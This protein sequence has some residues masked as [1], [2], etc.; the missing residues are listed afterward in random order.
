MPRIQRPNKPGREVP[1]TRLRN[2]KQPHAVHRSMWLLLLACAHPAPPVAPDPRDAPLPELCSREFT[3]WQPTREPSGLVVMTRQQV[4]R[5]V[6]PSMVTG[7]AGAC[8][9]I[10]EG[11]AE[12]G[13]YRLRITAQP[14]RGVA[15]ARFRWS[16]ARE[17]ALSEC[18][19]VLETTYDAWD[20]P[21]SDAID[22][23]TPPDADCAATL[24]YPLVFDLSSPGE[25]PPGSQRSSP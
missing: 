1:T 13:S 20:M 22:P 7:L 10:A 4:G 3:D 2:R 18:V 8:A 11:S 5:M 6:A 24:V 17:G 23:T 9:C 16:D 25:A 19:G 14:A 21:C 12:P 15:E